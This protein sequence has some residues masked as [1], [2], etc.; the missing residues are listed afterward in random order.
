MN[1]RVSK[2]KN[3][4]HTKFIFSFMN[5]LLNRDD[6]SARYIFIFVVA[7]LK[8]GGRGGLAEMRACLCRNQ[9]DS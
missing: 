9:H 7:F 1:E 2:S 4:T 5:E 8:D 3:T 6:S